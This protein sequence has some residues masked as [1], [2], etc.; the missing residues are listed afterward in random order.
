MTCISSSSNDLANNQAE[1][2][3]NADI[4][5]SFLEAL[6]IYP[7]CGRRKIIL[8]DDGKVYGRNELVARYIK[9]RTGKIRTR[10]QV[11]SHL[12]VLTKRRS[13]ELQLLRQD[14]QAQQIIL[15]RLRQSAITDLQSK[16][17][18]DKQSSRMDLELSSGSSSESEISISP[19]Q[20]LLSVSLQTG[21]Q[22]S[23]DSID[24]NH[25]KLPMTYAKETIKSSMFLGLM[26]RHSPSLR[27]SE[28]FFPND[29]LTLIKRH[30]GTMISR[31]YCI[32][33]TDKVKLKISLGEPCNHCP[34]I[35]HSI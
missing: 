6:A 12:Q 5:Q 3:W 8:T 21:D 25:R 16:L 32:R 26:N 35:H 10:K 31:D 15:E 30:R 24:Q 4:E 20:N 17:Q 7:P 9:I 13:K 14:K 11:S 2:I 1:T 28:Y 18:E 33:K 34:I 19:V 27:N 22:S 29:A 23:I